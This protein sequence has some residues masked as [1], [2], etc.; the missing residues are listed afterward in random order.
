MGSVNPYY[1][2]ADNNLQDFGPE[3]GPAREHPLQNADQEV[4]QRGTYES[5]INS[6]LRD[7]RIDVV[8]MLAD[9]FC[10]PRCQNFL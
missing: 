7:S 5:T 3:T 2:I 6:H 1:K 4:S 8:T 10:N 9:I